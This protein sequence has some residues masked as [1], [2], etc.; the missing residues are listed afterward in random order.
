[1]TE[2]IS[3]NTKKN[4]RIIEN[5]EKDIDVVIHEIPKAK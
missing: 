3:E 5:N 2:E 4:K 1:M